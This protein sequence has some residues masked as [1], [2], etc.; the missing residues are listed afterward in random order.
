MKKKI[1]KIPF[2]LVIFGIIFGLGLD[3]NLRDI[4]LECESDPEAG[5]VILPHANAGYLTRTVHD[6]MSI[7]G[8]SNN[9]F[10]LFK[11][12]V[13]VYT[14]ENGFFS[15]FVNI[16][17][18]ENIFVFQNGNYV[19][20]LVVNRVEPTPTPPVRREYLQN[21]YGIAMSPS[22]SRF[23]NGDDDNNHGTPLAR[24]TSFR[25]VAE[26]DDMYIIHDGSYVF[27]NRVERLPAPLEEFYVGDFEVYTEEK[28]TYVL[29][30][31]SESYLP[32]YTINVD[33]DGLSVEI[34][35]YHLS[36]EMN[37]FSFRLEK[38]IIGHYVTFVDNNQMKVGFKHPPTRLED[39][40]VMLDAGHG[41]ADPGALGPL[42]RMGPVEYDFNLIVMQLTAEHLQEHGVNV[43]QVYTC[44]EVTFPALERMRYFERTEY[45]E[46][47]PN[48]PDLLISIHAN[49]MP[50]H[51][52]FRSEE[53]PLMFYTLDQSERAANKIL[54]HVAQRLYNERG[55]GKPAESSDSSENN[56]SE[57]VIR[58]NFAMARHTAGSSMLFE[59]GFM[60]NPVDY[61]RMLESDYLALIAESL[62]EGILAYLNSTLRNP[63]AHEASAPDD[64]HENNNEENNEV[65]E[66][67]ETDSDHSEN[68]N[69]NSNDKNKD[70]SGSRMWWLIIAG[71]SVIIIGAGVGLGYLYVKKNNK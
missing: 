33:D 65:Y 42:G 67:N 24:G 46:H 9:S 23:Y 34:I 59:M 71:A 55:V 41:G 12:G 56:W 54:S 36:G 44:S 8:A 70:N 2:V 43:L 25:I 32:P 3:W 28:Y 26:Y 20:E 60:C 66:N 5:F 62:S 38:P 10:P 63:V 22:L 49:S 7:L 50:V 39:T 4:T 1:R 35:L 27:T 16:A 37:N 21:A 69:S 40:L 61:E 57:H 29:F 19:H 45:S 51:N 68:Y 13:E 18:G 48:L 58:R 15:I 6:R 17:D 47:Y 64:I 53:G 11:N 30:E 52:N 31:L 14:T